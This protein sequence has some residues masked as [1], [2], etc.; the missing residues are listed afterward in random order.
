MKQL[1]VYIDGSCSGNPGP[2]GYAAVCQENGKT[3]V[4]GGHALEATNNKMELM[5]AVHAL[6]TAIRV[7]GCDITFH[8]DSRYL[9][10]CFSHDEKW[11]TQKGR[12]NSELWEKLIKARDNGKHTIRFVKVAGHAGVKLN[13][14]ADKY[15]RAECAKARHNLYENG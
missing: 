8:T 4:A 5:A 13:E 10:V 15:A 6:E 12:A 2:G 14:L 1:D 9:I 3:K 7:K 11:L